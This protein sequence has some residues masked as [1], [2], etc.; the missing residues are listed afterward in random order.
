MPIPIS[1]NLSILSIS[2]RCQS[3]CRERFRG[4][5]RKTSEKNYQGTS[6]IAFFTREI[7]KIRSKDRFYLRTDFGKEIDKRE[8]QF[9]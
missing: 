5:S 6:N 1:K 8:R 7:C 9:K 3:V 4:V 2:I